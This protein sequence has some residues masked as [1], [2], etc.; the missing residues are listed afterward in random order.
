MRCDRQGLRGAAPAPRPTGQ[1]SCC[2]LV[3]A[4]RLP[5]LFLQWPYQAWIPGALAAAGLPAQLA[6]LSA[7]SRSV[8]AQRNA[9]FSV[10]RCFSLQREK[11]GR[12]RRF[13]PARRLRDR[14]HWRHGELRG[15]LAS[16]SPPSSFFPGEAAPAGG[17]AEAPRPAGFLSRPGD[18]G[19]RS[20]SSL[21]LTPFLWCCC[22]GFFVCL[23]SLSADAVLA[24]AAGPGGS[25]GASPGRG[26]ARAPRQRLSPA[27]ASRPGLCQVSKAVHFSLRLERRLPKRSDSRLLRPRK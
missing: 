19:G 22:S 24:V 13:P 10:P 4:V 25:H 5:C 7:D 20:G 23:F 15:S 9:S 17:S 8:E 18:V 16:R 6:A 1:A 26:A 11:A 3:L 14:T 2:A 21:S 27:A 12:T